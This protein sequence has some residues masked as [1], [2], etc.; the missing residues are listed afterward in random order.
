MGETSFLAFA[1]FGEDLHLS[2]HLKLTTPLSRPRQLHIEW[3]THVHHEST[4]HLQ[5]IKS[6]VIPASLRVHDKCVTNS[7]PF[8][9]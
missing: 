6:T 3:D 5:A 1:E 8:R 7:E 4:A 2:M 9:L